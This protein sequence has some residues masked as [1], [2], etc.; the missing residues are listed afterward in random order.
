MVGAKR[1]RRFPESNFQYGGGAAVSKPIKDE[2][3]KRMAN[4]FLAIAMVALAA[5]CSG[6]KENDAAAEEMI[7]IIEE[8][9]TLLESAKDEAS[10]KAA[11]VKFDA[12][13]ERTKALKKR[14]A[15]LPKLTKAED[16]AL[17]K[18]FEARAEPLKKRIETEMGR[19]GA[20]PAI[21]QNLMESVMK[22]GQEMATLK[23]A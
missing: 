19:I 15:S 23:P 21:A 11:A 14:V 13:T 22:F 12:L 8:F 10:A 20:N 3:M 17:T 4:L 5:G 16:D 1:F 6:L 18:K 9:A 2:H 7:S